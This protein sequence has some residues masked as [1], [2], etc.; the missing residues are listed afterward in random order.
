MMEPNIL[1]SVKAYLLYLVES[2]VQDICLS[3]EKD[4]K[5]PLDKKTTEFNLSETKLKL[6]TIEKELGDCRRCSLS[7]ERNRIVFGQGNHGADI[8]FIGDIPSHEAD[9]G[10]QLFEGERGQLLS[11]IIEKG[12]NI[13]CSEIYLCNIV[14]CRPDQERCP[15]DEEIQACLPFLIRQIDAINPKVIVLLGSFPVQMLLQ[16]T[17][18]IEQLRGKWHTYKGIPVMPTFHPAYV[19]LNYTVPIRKMVWEDVQKVK[20]FIVNGN[21]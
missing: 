21:F 15:Q 11:N 1:Q 2:S 10:G 13:A 18:S 14:K 8:L 20:Q 16:T 17:E 4:C 19:L 3:A 12:M 6:S 7:R 9:Q 5:D